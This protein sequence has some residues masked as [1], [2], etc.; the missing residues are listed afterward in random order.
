MGMGDAQYLDFWLVQVLI[1]P[2]RRIIVGSAP[3]ILYGRHKV[4]E[5]P[6]VPMCLAFDVS[7]RTYI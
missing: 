3:V 7:G 2:F 5:Q 6:T 4:S 1:N